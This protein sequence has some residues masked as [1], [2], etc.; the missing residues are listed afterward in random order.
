[1]GM[2]KGRGR[3]KAKVKRKG[4]IQT[5]L[6]RFVY[7]RCP[8]LIYCGFRKFVR[9]KTWKFPLGKQPHPGIQLQGSYTS[10]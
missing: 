5:Y 1:M 10:K 4:I 8:F 9:I 7:Y 3:R 6:G 2:G